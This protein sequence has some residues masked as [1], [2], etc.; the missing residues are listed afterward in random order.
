MT[1]EGCANAARK[2]LS[3]LETDISD[4]QIDVSTKR[5]VVTTTLPVNSILETLQKTGKNASRFVK[6]HAFTTLSFLQGNFNNSNSFIRASKQA[7]KVNEVLG[8]MESL[9]RRIIFL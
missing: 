6:R 8:I 2:V 5:V 9:L 4:V 3:K 1:C 7:T